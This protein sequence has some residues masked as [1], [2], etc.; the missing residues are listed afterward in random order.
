[1]R[2]RA[3]AASAQ[4]AV[5]GPLAKMF[6]AAARKAPELRGFGLPL[7]GFSA[8]NNHHPRP[9]SS[10]LIKSKQAGAGRTR[11]PASGGWVPALS[12]SR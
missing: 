6:A 2:S 1:M 3:P 10:T 7:G 12:T 11:G 5:G 9:P 4:K 8:A